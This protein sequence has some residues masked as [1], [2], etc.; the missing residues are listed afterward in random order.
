MLWLGIVSQSGVGV[1]WDCGVV[2]GCVG[3]VWAENCVGG[4]FGV[5]GCGDRCMGC[6]VMCLSVQEC[7]HM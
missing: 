7:A 4:V 6:V 1:V 3:C 2:F 5:C